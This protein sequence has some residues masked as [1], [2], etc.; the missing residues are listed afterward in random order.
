MPILIS[1]GT[2]SYTGQLAR[3]CEVKFNGITIGTHAR[4]VI[5]IYE[6][7]PSFIT[8]EDLL[9]AVSKAKN[10]IKINLYG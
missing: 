5:S 2:N 1:G 7:A 10:L 6:K 8:N 4:K 9:K 3:Q